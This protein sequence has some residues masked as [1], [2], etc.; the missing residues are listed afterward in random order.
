MGDGFIFSGKLTGIGRSSSI[1]TKASG[2]SH[3]HSRRGSLT[4]PVQV[5]LASDRIMSWR[6]DIEGRAS[7]SGTATRSERSTSPPKPIRAPLNAS[8]ANLASEARKQP[9]ASSPVTRAPNASSPTSSVQTS[10][11]LLRLPKDKDPGPTLPPTPSFSMLSASDSDNQET[12]GEGS[13][14]NLS[15]WKGGI[16]SLKYPTNAAS[17][18]PSG[19]ETSGHIKTKSESYASEG[20]TPGRRSMAGNELR[21]SKLG[22]DGSRRKSADPAQS[23]RPRVSESNLK[24]VMVLERATTREGIHLGNGRMES[25]VA[26]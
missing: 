21:K 15:R 20:K 13:F 7:I 26:P 3:V 8:A 22:D 25:G 2:G 5:Q 16:S 1:V 24:G 12:K 11:T 6:Q 4:R 19:N 23:S 17:L 18:A 10:K 14:W 9:Y